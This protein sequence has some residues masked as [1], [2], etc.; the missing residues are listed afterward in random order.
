MKKAILPWNASLSVGNPLLD[1]E[2]HFICS[3][4]NELLALGEAGEKIQQQLVAQSVTA[5]LES[6]RRHFVS[7]EALM[8][9]AGYP[10]LLRHQELHRQLEDELVQFQSRPE[11]VVDDQLEAF[12]HAWF[13][14][15]LQEE[16][17]KYA[18]YLKH[19]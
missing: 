19:Q 8:A 3:L 4:M 13:L 14:H 6:I 11:Q 9:D 15:H 2:H 16:D 1:N 17:R 12:L 18:D 7:E 10:D 5:L